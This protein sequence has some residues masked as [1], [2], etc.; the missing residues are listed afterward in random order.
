MVGIEVGDRYT[1]PSYLQRM[2]NEKYPDT[3]LVENMGVD[4]YIVDQQTYHLT[5]NVNLA[6]GDIVIFY[7]GVNDGAYAFFCCSDIDLGESEK[8]PNKSLFERS[9]QKFIHFLQHHSVFYQEFIYSQNTP[10][11]HLWSSKSKNAITGKIEEDY[12]RYLHKAFEYTT[13]NGAQFFHF[14]Q[15]HIFSGQN[16][17][18]YEEELIPTFLPSGYGKSIEIGY[19]ALNQALERLEAEGMH[20]KDLTQI[21]DPSNRP[22]ETEYFFDW[23]HVNHLGNQVIASYIFDEISPYLDE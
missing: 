18:L 20:N 13:Q 23:C 3:Y 9:I 15:P 5:H 17:S 6:S 12:Y 1:I 2:I 22:P 11:F 16:N 10:P 21:L 4:A 7:D 14:L 8:A 19:D